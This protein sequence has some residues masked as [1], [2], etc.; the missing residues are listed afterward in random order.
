[1][2]HALWVLHDLTPDRFFAMPTVIQQWVLASTELEVEAMRR[3]ARG[4]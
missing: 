2:L 3:K 1:M 4:S